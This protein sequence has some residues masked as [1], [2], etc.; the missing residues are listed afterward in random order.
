MYDKPRGA[1]TG[2]VA[3]GKGVRG[4]GVR[5]SVWFL[6]GDRVTGQGVYKGNMSVSP[7]LLLFLSPLP[8]VPLTCLALIL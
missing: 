7:P 1:R 4:K 3:R 2:L 6:F 8:N 5:R